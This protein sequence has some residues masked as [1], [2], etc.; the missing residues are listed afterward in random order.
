MPRVSPNY[1]QARE[2]HVLQAAAYC[3]SRTG[4]RL[5]S[6]NDIAAEAGLSVGAL[7]RYFP[8]K[9]ALFR[10]LFLSAR[11]D[12]EA[13]WE[14]ARAGSAALE[15]LRTMIDLH[16]DAVGDEDCLW[17]VALD[18]RLR[19]EALDDETLAEHVRESYDA[20][21][22]ELARLLT[23]DGAARRNR[24]AARSAAMAIIALI[25]EARYQALIDTN[26]DMRRYK[27]QVLKIGRDVIASLESRR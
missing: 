22:T 9:D 15:R 4:Y 19:A 21:I 27:T 24:K 10:S 12:R 14:K 5:T 11:Q 3:F 23:P 6:M 17:A 18:V 8:S 16:F 2:Q 1:A 20:Q 7:Y 25:N 13:M 26:V